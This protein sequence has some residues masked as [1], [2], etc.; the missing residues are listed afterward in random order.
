VT[1]NCGV[2]DS[3]LGNATRIAALELLSISNSRAAKKEVFLGF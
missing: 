2:Y 3:S 1:W